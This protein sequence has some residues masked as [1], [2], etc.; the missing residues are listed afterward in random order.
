MLK[1]I[2]IVDDEPNNLNLLRQVLK[3]KFQL[4]FAN[5]GIKALSAA[6]EHRPDLILLD[7]M[8]PDISGYDVCEKLKSNPLTK[9]IPVIFVSAMSDT[10]DEAKGFDVGAVDYIQKPISGAIVLRRVQTHLSLVKVNELEKVQKDAVFM[11][12]EAG[13]YNDN[14]T[15]DHIWRMA[16]YSRL[17]ASAAG[18]TDEMAELMELAA[19]MHDT[20]KI[21]I[22]DEILKAPRKLTPEEWVIMKQHTQI[23]ADILNKS[24]SKLIHLAS[25]IALSHHEKW[26]GSGY[27][28]NL[29]GEAIP[30]SGRIVAITDVFDALSMKRP[31]KDAWP[32]EDVID[33]IV[34]NAG[35]AFD[36][37]LV[38]IFQQILP[39]I[40]EVKLAWDNKN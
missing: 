35:S 12:G 26:D 32:V 23:G 4:I 15:G 37:R 28:N 40:L 31:Y 19:P 21:G 2:L 5:C 33:E 11:L 9:A 1:K 13:H 17:L 7:I 6:Q 20:G 36:P 29:A 14:D 24:D 27:P 30:E 34:K 16:A 22:P 3:G 18:W 25:E 8:M 10:E 38:D 39:Q